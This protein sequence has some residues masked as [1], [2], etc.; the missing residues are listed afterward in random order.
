MTPYLLANLFFHHLLYSIT[1]ISDE[2]SCSFTRIQT[3]GSKVYC[4][5]SSTQGQ[6]AMQPPLRFFFQIFLFSVSFLSEYERNA[7]RGN[8]SI[9]WCEDHHEC[10]DVPMPSSSHYYCCRH[11]RCCCYFVAKAL[12]NHISFIFMTMKLGR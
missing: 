12:F 8:K 1:L 4:L 2:K 11:R 6:M 10:Q 7:S 3:L 9:G 5:R